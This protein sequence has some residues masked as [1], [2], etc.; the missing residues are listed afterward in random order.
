[1]VDAFDEW[2]YDESRQV[3]DHAL[4][5][6][7]YGYHIMYF[8]GYSDT[9]YRD[10]IITSDLRNADLQTWTNEVL[11]RNNVEDVNLS[12]VDRDL[13]LYNYFYYGY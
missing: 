10:Y 5:E 3:G 8:S 2:C 12:R 11:S 7:D 13:V 1:M 6:T 9:T 4:I